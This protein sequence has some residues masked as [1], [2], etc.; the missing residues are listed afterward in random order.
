M[1]SIYEISVSSNFLEFPSDLNSIGDK[2]DKVKVLVANKMIYRKY[3]EKN[4]YTWKEVEKLLVLFKNL[5][6]IYICFNSIT[7]VSSI[8]TL[9][10]LKHINIE[11][12]L[13]EDFNE[14]LK[15]DQL[16]KFV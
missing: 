9:N 2:F 16:P 11:G 1:P 15:L 14:I 13:L 6:E 8:L 7:N 3:P 4:F 5:Q 10:Q 12:N